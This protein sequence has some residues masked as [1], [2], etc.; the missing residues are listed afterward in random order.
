MSISPKES[1]DTHYHYR[2]YRRITKRSFCAAAEGSGDL[3]VLIGL[4]SLYSACL[5]MQKRVSDM[6][7]WDRE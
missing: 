6:R 7:I 4:P 3:I 1:L 2:Y 5:I